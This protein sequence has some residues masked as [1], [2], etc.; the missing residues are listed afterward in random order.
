LQIA[1][2][3][4]AEVM[5]HMR[6]KSV[7]GNMDWRYDIQKS[8]AQHKKMLLFGIQ[9]RLIEITMTIERYCRPP[10]MEEYKRKIKAQYPA[11]SENRIVKLAKNKT[12]LTILKGSY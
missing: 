2:M 6:G 9:M 3:S 4:D 1:A 12:E 7:R 5:L 8:I 11:A 10:I